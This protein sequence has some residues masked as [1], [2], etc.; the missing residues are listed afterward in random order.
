MGAAMTQR[1]HEGVMTTLGGRIDHRNVLKMAAGLGVASF[2]VLA[3]ATPTLARWDDRRQ[4]RH[5]GRHD[6]DDRRHGD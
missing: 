5:D 2:G 4:D 3:V 1:H 6:R